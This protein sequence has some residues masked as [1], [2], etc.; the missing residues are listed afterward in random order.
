MKNTLLTF[1]LT[2]I[3]M[4]HS[5]AQAPDLSD[6]CIVEMKKLYYLV[7][8]WK[9]EVIYRTPQGQELRL[10]QEEHI[11]LKL[12]GLVITIDGRGLKQDEDEIVFQS[13][14][15]LHFDPFAQQF[16]FKSFLK[17]GYSVDAYFKVLEE[18]KF[19]WGFDFPNRGKYRYTI[20]LDPS[21]KTWYE[22]GEFSSDGNDWFMSLEMNL[23]KQKPSYR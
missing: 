12:Q 23:N 15:I 4:L 10:L 7:G 14:A 16:R 3:S 5:M 11:E 2:L 9:G 6:S 8:D 1:F 19:E 13:F 21:E 22:T 20:M 17:E 18:N